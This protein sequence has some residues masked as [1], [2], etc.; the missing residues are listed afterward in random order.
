ML[1]IVDADLRALRST[2][3]STSPLKKTWKDEVL[4]ALFKMNSRRVA[5]ND[6]ATST[7][8]ET[9][10]ADSNGR[11]CMPATHACRL[12]IADVAHST[13]WVLVWAQAEATTMA[14][15][16]MRAMRSKPEYTSD[17]EPQSRRLYS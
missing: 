12:I 13:A 3:I 8:G 10:K 5:Y 4:S 17:E 14:S 7:K 11:A 6:I 1:V 2:R 9:T 15:L 16:T